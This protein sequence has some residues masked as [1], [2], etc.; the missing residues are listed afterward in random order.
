VIR[1]LSKWCQWI[2]NNT[3]TRQWLPTSRWRT[4]TRPCSISMPCSS[5]FSAKGQELV[6][7]PRLQALQPT[8]GRLLFKI[9]SRHR[10]LM[11]PW[12]VCPLDSLWCLQCQ[13]ECQE[14]YLQ[15][16]WE[17]LARTQC[18][19]SNSCQ[20]QD[21][22]QCR[23]CTLINRCQCIL[24]KTDFKGPKTIK[25]EFKAWKEYENLILKLACLT[26]LRRDNW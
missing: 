8:T 2:S 21:L 4:S 6:Q 7:E 15:V 22:S 25:S 3:T 23:W 24:L 20:C 11:L 26:F 9:H 10:I 5:S 19:S 1:L 13:L 14:C 17:T 16:V 12:P 18:S